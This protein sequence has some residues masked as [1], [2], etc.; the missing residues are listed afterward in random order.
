LR[1][2]RTD[3]P[4]WRGAHDPW[5]LL[6]V[7]CCGSSPLARG[8]PT[9]VF[10]ATSDHRIIPAGAG[11]TRDTGGCQSAGADHPRW[12]GAHE[13]GATLTDAQ[14]GSS[15]LARGPQ[16]T[17]PVQVRVERIIPA[18]A[19]PTPRHPRRWCAPTD[20]PR[21]RGA[22]VWMAS[23]RE[24]SSGSSPLARGPLRSVG[25][26]P[27][28]GRIIPAGAGPT[29]SHWFSGCPNPDHPRWR[30]AHVRCGGGSVK[31]GGS[32]PLARGP[33]PC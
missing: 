9:Q 2:R 32:S 8:P 27:G 5:H 33:L 11:P 14:F 21:W 15:P 25:V 7:P 1:T 10:T 28:S 17:H 4:R 12:R 16:T 20:H 13:S 24:S 19:G 30:G 31:Q 29:A 6:G 23:R 26:T 18:G 22:H 3:H